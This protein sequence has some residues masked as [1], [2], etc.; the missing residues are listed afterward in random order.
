MY[1]AFCAL[2]L[3]AVAM[4]SKPKANALTTTVPTTF[5][6]TEFFILF[7]L[8]LNFVLRAWPAYL[9]LR[10]TRKR[11]MRLKVRRENKAQL[12]EGWHEG[13]AARKV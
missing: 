6:T 11:Y 4:N 7:L 1:W 2:A 13:F 9:Y 10:E 5:L 3:C 8:E 12:T